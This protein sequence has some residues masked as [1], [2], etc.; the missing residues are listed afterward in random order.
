MSF[1]SL[2]E[3]EKPESWEKEKEKWSKEILNATQG[4]QSP[5]K[6]RAMSSS[7]KGNKKSETFRLESSLMSC[8][9]VPPHG[10]PRVSPSCTI[11]GVLSWKRGEEVVSETFELAWAS[12]GEH[13]L[14]GNIIW[15]WVCNLGGI[16]RRVQKLCRRVKWRPTPGW[17]SYDQG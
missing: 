1:P 6:K 16:H 12:L 10:H 9:C 3:F 5:W 2:S 8:T 11:R 17:S 15:P 14:S 7:L 13:S 4:K